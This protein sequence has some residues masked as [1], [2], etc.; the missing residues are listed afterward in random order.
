[1]SM[2]TPAKRGSSCSSSKTK[3]PVSQGPGISWVERD[4]QGWE[5]EEICQLDGQRAKVTLASHVLACGDMHPHS[6]DWV[7]LG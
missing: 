5:S 4:G 6:G 2:R 3:D 7:E 1:M